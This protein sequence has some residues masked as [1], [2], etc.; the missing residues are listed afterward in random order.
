[1]WTATFWKDALERAG[2]TFAQTAIPVVSAAAA[3]GS[4]GA[5]DWTSAGIIIG[6]AVVLSI[7]T[8]MLSS[9]VGSDKNASLVK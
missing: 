3:A 2:K 1:M 9:R 6:G 7:L 8:S 4:L 5:I